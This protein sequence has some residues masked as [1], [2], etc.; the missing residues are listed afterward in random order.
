[1]FEPINSAEQTAEQHF[2]K[3][4][5]VFVA[6]LLVMFLVLAV[7]LFALQILNTDVYSSISSN[8]QMRIVSQPAKRGDIY[9]RNGVMLAGS[10]ICYEICVSTAAS[11]GDEV[12]TLANNLAAYLK[13]PE[14]TAE[15]ILD[16]VKS[17][18]RAYQP[19]VITTIEA[20]GNQHLLAALEENRD[21]LPGLLIIEEPRRVYPGG[22]L[23]SH[24]LGQMGQ[25]S[26]T[27]EELLDS[28][29]YLATDWVGKAGL[30]KTMERFANSEGEEIGLR[31][32]R[33][34]QILEVN[35]KNR[36]VRTVSSEPSVSG[37]SLVLTLD[38]NVQAAM[39]KSL[40]DTVAK[41]SKSRPKAQA[42]AG[43]LLDVKTGAVLGLASYP[44]YEPENFIIG[45][46][47]ELSSYY[48]DEKLK[49]TYNRAV[50]AAY[51]V[52]STF[53]VSTALAALVSGVI[54]AETEVLCSAKTWTI[55]KAKCTKEHGW[56]NMREAMAV[57]C[58]TYFQD[59]A[60]M[61]G[62]ESMYDTFKKLGYGQLTGI[63]L[64]G[65][66]RGL[67]ANPEYKQLNFEGR[68]A[69]WHRYDTHYMAIGQGYSY[70]T[71]LQMAQAVATIANGG[72]RMQPHLVDKIVDYQGETVYQWQPR[73]MDE[74]E[75]S[76]YAGRVL[77]D[78]MIAVTQ[79]GGTGYS[80]FGNYPVT[81]AAKTGTAQTG[82]A[83]DDK[84]KDYHGWFIAYA[85][86]EDPQ[87]AFAG[88]IEYGYHGYASAG[89]VCKAA[90]DA[91]FGYEGLTTAPVY[92]SVVE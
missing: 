26:D 39:E 42:G 36:I 52:G 71:P 78:S 58:N 32:Q 23:A 4:T 15:A 13:D 63:E 76:D 82:L 59:V 37:N 7:K 22:N 5:L 3:R 67:L 47:G 24:L 53:K 6:V 44:D 49:P 83:G 29:A 30:E 40:K 34:L 35:S 41:I 92:S 20:E 28:Y 79:D 84:N 46:D 85:P 14:L 21:D 12:N 61:A 55:E 19:V 27:D 70:Y 56:V 87:V 48:Y 11:R 16:K 31:G 2:S 65:E 10:E 69:I 88:M 8:N 1:M 91:Y 77:R 54:D 43:V 51:P 72:V 73:V 45:L 38:A 80:M 89:A 62:I 9:D 81:V 90:F 86:A 25:I 18:P 74:I 75:I 66:S 68:D 50:S 17:N 60:A 57:S 33:G 64:T